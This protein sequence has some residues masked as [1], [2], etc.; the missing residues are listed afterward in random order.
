MT[1][2][3]VWLPQIEPRR[4]TGGGDCVTACPEDA[5]ALQRGTAVL[6]RP[7]ACTYCAACEHACPTHAIALPYQLIL[8]D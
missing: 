5:L 4:C 3:A 6:I 7:E 1:R 2:E 8:A